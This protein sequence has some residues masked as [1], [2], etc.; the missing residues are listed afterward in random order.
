MAMDMS[1]FVGWSGEKNRNFQLN[2]PIQS[3]LALAVYRS[4]RRHRTEDPSCIICGVANEDVSHVLRECF[5][6][7]SLWSR[8]VK[9]ERLDEFLWMECHKW[10]ILNLQQP[11]YFPIQ[12]ADWYVLFGS[13][14]WSLWQQRNSLVFGSDD[15]ISDNTFQ[16]GYR[17]MEKSLRVRQLVRCGRSSATSQPRIIGRCDAVER[18]SSDL[19]VARVISLLILWQGWYDKVLLNI[20]DI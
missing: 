20:I 13:L 3:P 16:R 17:L 12:G 10:L 4:K 6:A 9:V 1:D 8:L 19:L 14:L 2:Q 5:A 7:R 18:S 15:Y 11:N